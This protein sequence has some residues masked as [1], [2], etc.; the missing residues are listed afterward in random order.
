MPDHKDPLRY[1]KLRIDSRSHIEQVNPVV[2]LTCQQRPC[3]LFCPS[4]VFKW[5]DRELNI[6]YERCVE[7]GACLR[8]CPHTNIHW[9]Y[10]RAGYGIAHEL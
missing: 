7:C 5:V 2:C 10:P 1:I 6:S 3:L 9:D 4:Q 8:G